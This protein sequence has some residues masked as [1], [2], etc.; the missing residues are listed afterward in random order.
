LGLVAFGFFLTVLVLE[1]APRLGGFIILSLQEHRNALAMRQKGAYRIMCIG[2]STTQGQYPALLEQALNRSDTG[3]RFSV[4][5]RG[6]AATRT[7][8]LVNRLESDI[9]VYHPDMV[10]AMMGCNDYG[11]HMP[12]EP[13]TSSIAGQFIRALRTYKLARI[14][15]QHI[16]SLGRMSGT[17]SKA[18]SWRRGEMMTLRVK[19]T[20]RKESGMNPT[21][22]GDHWALG[23]AHENG[24]KY[25]EATAYKKALEINPGND[26]AYCD[27]GLVLQE[28][29]DL[30][31]AVAAYKKALEINPRN[32][33]VYVA[34]GAAYREGRKFVQ[35]EAA[36]KKALDINS[37]D[38]DVDENANAWLVVVYRD[39]G[40]LAKTVA[41][42]KKVLEINPRN[43]QAYEGML[44]AYMRGFGDWSQ[45]RRWLEDAVKRTTAPPEQLFD[46]LS[47]VYTEMGD[48]KLAKYYCD[49]AEALRLREY[50]PSVARSYHRLKEILERRGVK[51]VCVQ[52]PLRN[53][54]PLR[55]IFQG[56]EAGIVFVDNEKIFKDAVKKSSI[57][58]YFMD[59]FAGDFG[60]CTDKGNALLA[61]NI[62]DVLLREVFGK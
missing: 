19:E 54:A 51:L 14:A 26:Q 62:A 22:D 38:E 60:H 50:N 45:P 3:I 16:A 20:S 10:L 7:P 25:A 24:G 42:S 44:W 59:M 40:K 47:T 2:E 58:V 53:I 33:Q 57:Q 56:R 49:K 41:A 55:K 23:D 52:Y 18:L 6:L 12:Y 30:T 17:H 29:G 9:D 11:P 5:D 4:I 48:T 61:G 21:T 27:L 39:W 8:F 1:V 34:L 37:G 15:W 13:E 36:L 32:C 43:K 46:A 35:A 31:A 28:Q